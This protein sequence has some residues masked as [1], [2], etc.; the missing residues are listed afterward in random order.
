MNFLA[1]VAKPPKA[2]KDFD[3]AET[4][5]LLPFF[6]YLFLAVRLRE[7]LQQRLGWRAGTVLGNCV[8]V[9]IGGSPCLLGLAALLLIRLSLVALDILDKVTKRRQGVRYPPR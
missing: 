5:L 6:I 3:E 2:S 8:I 4:I 1:E 9:V 7:L